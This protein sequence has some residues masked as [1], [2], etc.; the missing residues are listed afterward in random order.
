MRLLFLAVFLI[1]N[2]LGA[3]HCNAQGPGTFQWTNGAPNNN[4]GLSGAKF[5]VDKNSY[6]WYEWTNGTNWVQC[7]DRIQQIS[8]CAAPAYTP[9]IH[10]AYFVVNGCTEPEFYYWN[11]TAW[12]LL[13]GGATYTAGTG[14]AISGGNV[15]SNTAPNVNQTIS[16]S[17]Q[18]LTL[19]DGGGTVTIP[20]GVTWPL[21]APNSAS[22]QYSVGNGTGGMRLLNRDFV[23]EGGVGTSNRS[24]SVTIKTSDAPNLVNP[25]NIRS[26]TTGLTGGIITIQSGEGED[27]GGAINIFGGDCGT[28]F[29]GGFTLSAGSSSSSGNGGVAEFRAGN[30]VSGV[31]G[32]LN[33]YGGAGNDPTS[34][35][36]N[37]TFNSYDPKSGS[38]GKITFNTE[39][40]LI[41]PVI[42]NS[43]GIQ[44][45]GLTTAQRDALTGLTA[46][47]VLWNSTLS[48]LQVYNGTTWE[49]LH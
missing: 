37:I 30:S 15:I 14:I 48:K 45:K 44:Y 36:G 8:G 1:V 31:G 2:L 40:G 39:S 4:P 42:F 46:G 33:F 17:G 19:S 6:R 24:N 16:L 47:R 3:K 41:N 32:D 29:A 22:P 23:I 13:N 7:G 12:K 27:E 34:V 49:N 28:G 38:G 43:A 5:A 20:S 9:T 10:N 35:S 11:G 25:L 18:N 26:G 21:L